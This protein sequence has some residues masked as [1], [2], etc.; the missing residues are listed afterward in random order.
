VNIDPAVWP[1]VALYALAWWLA[2]ELIQER[3]NPK[4][5]IAWIIA[6]VLMPFFGIP[7]YYMFGKNR[8]KGLM[9]RRAH[10]DQHALSPHEHSLDDLVR[11]PAIRENL[12]HLEKDLGKDGLPLP[13]N[14]DEMACTFGRFGELHDPSRNSVKLLVD[15]VDTF[16]EIFV[17]ISGARHYILV[18]Y[19]ILRSDRL[20]LELQKLLIAKAR[21]GVAVHVIYDDI[22]SFWLPKAYVRDLKAAGISVASFLPIHS[23]KR[24][25]QLNFRNHRKLVVVDGEIALTGGLNFGE[26][27]VSGLPLFDKADTSR[28]R[29]THVRIDG[30]AVARLEDVFFDDWHFATGESLEVSLRAR[31]VPS[32]PEH[33]KEV[34]QVIP[35]GPTDEALVGV[36]LYMLTIQKAKKRLWIAT[37]YF[38]PDT[39]LTR[40]LE[41]CTLRGVDVRI[42][43]P[44]RSDNILVHWVGV[45]YAAKL[46]KA[47]VRVL[48]YEPGFMHQKVV[49]VDDDMCL[50]GST[51]FDNRALYLN[52]ETTLVIHGRDFARQVDSMLTLDMAESCATLDPLPRGKVGRF[53]QTQK[54]NLSRLLAPLL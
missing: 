50:I 17:A 41:L 12:K 37:P 1:Y 22:G 14:L 21:S 19:Y 11:Q 23:W 16:K 33:P 24:G 44:R 34:V 6:L 31:H 51:N 2:F 47:G 9:R 38:V 5:T 40:E 8:I 27:Y 10:F 25:L 3:R 13:R 46:R 39:P 20:G 54:E 7:L 35:S 32:F 28:W 30:P 36:L 49:L 52:F 15:G 53:L 43:L 4:S 26:E 48:F 42:M 18:Q 45:T 29:D